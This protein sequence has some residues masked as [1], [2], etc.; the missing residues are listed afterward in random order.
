VRGNPLGWE[1][2]KAIRR[3][4]DALEAALAAAPACVC[5]DVDGMAVYS[6][7]C[8]NALHR[9]RAAAP[10]SSPQPDAWYEKKAALEE[11]HDVTV[12][13][14]PFTPKSSPDVAHPESCMCDVCM[15]AGC[16]GRKHHD[17]CLPRRTT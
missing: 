16:G 12:G 8:P 17:R 11:G 4:A 15:C 7:A 1:Q 5:E 3:C 2:E 14:E 13:G 9:Q 6:A 10:A